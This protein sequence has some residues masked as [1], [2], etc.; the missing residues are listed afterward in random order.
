MPAI[1]ANK[2][3][4][5]NKNKNKK[6][7]TNKNRKRNKKKNKNTRRAAQ[8]ILISV[9]SF[10]VQCLSFILIDRK[11]FMNSK[12]PAE[13]PQGFQFVEKVYHIKRRTFPRLPLT[14]ELSP[15]RRLR[16]R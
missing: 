13:Q 16:E 8:W 2:N 14:R 15:L 5:T 12:S 10:S 9:H 1:A 11:S 6:T 7:N 3:K 4:N